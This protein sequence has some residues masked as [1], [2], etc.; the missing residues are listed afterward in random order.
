MV[1]NFLSHDSLYLYNHA[2]LNYARFLDYCTDRIFLRK[3]GG[4]YIFIHRLLLEHFAALTE[5]D[6]QRLARGD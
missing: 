6:I 3:G 4:G 1:C 5:A 2:P